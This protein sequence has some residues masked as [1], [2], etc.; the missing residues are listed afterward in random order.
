MENIVKIGNVQLLEK[1]VEKIYQE[2]K[3]I[4]SYT[5]IFQIFY[6]QAQKMYYGQKIIDYKGYAKRGRFFIQTAKQ[7]N[8]V[9]GK[10]VLIEE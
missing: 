5:G 2:G 6:S 7:I 1:D 4:C 10:K 8:H 9:L 3:Y